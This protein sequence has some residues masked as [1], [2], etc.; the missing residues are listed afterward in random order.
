MAFLALFLLSTG[1]PRTTHAAG[2]SFL[3]GLVGAAKFDADSLTFRV[4]AE[5]AADE[6][7]LSSM[8]QVGLFGQHFFAG[9]ATRV[10]VEGGALFGWRS[11]NTT[12]LLSQNQAVVKID[13]S[14]W[15]L[16]LSA[17]ICLNQRLGQ[18]WRLY[19]G[20][21]PAMVFAEY[22][23]DGKVKTGDA[24]DPETAVAVKG[25]TFSEFGIGVYGRVGLEYEYYPTSS[26]GISARGLAIDME[27]DNAVGSSG[28]N[29]VQGFITFTR[30]FRGY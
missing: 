24:A 6:E 26:I 29:G 30:H 20:A 11:R 25:E 18:R 14:F 5:G 28:V 13:T 12:V 10:G 8:P 21:G 1:L 23:E 4:P 22:K 9:E 27:F 17:G 15:M 16:D 3:Q 2:D 7:D 19:L